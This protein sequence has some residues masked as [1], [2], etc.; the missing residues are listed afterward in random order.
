MKIIIAIIIFLVGFAIGSVMFIELRE[1][2]ISCSEKLEVCEQNSEVIWE[3]LK[4]CLA[5]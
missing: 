4:E 2:E 5:K 1:S 3:N